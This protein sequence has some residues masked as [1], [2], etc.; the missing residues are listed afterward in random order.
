MHSPATTAALTLSLTG[1]FERQGTEAAEGVRLWAEM[2]GVRLT[3]V[4]DRG[5]TTAAARAYAAWINSKD[6]LIGPYASGLVR[7]VAP[8]VRDAGR[9]LW[10]HGGSADDLAQPGVVCL[11]APASSYFDGLVDEAVARRIDRLVVVQGTGPFAQAVADGA[12]TG[13][14]QRGLDVR[15]IDISAVDA[16]DAAESAFVLAGRFEDDVRVVRQA[17]S[18]RSIPSAPGRRGCRNP[19]IRP[20]TRRCRRRRP[21]A[22]A[23]VADPTQ[24][25]DRSFRNRL[26]CL[27][28]TP[29]QSRAFV[30]GRSGSRCWLSR[31]RRPPARPRGRG[32]AAVGYLN[33]ARRLRPGCRLAPGWPPR[34]DRPLAGWPD[35]PDRHRLNRRSSATML[36]RNRCRLARE[37]FLHFLKA[38]LAG[39]RLR[40]A[41]QLGQTRRNTIVIRAGGRISCERRQGQ[42]LNEAAQTPCP[43]LNGRLVYAIP[44]VCGQVEAIAKLRQS[45]QYPA[46]AASPTRGRLLRT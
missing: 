31:P 13:A 18:R 14:S 29:N 23:V 33:A 40:P 6:L 46:A 3:L 21:R 28:P 44:Y 34:D 38:G 37:R 39:G 7:A 36:G 25:G 35:G 15:A 32:R 42:L 11:P 17:A 16:E 10:N 45:C 26:W 30:P 22:R 41:T 43:S 27:L 9:L 12:T 8:L 2:A 5:S 20:G 19:G 24:A 4:D 1:P